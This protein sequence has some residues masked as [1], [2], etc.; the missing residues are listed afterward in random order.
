VLAEEM[1]APVG[2][3]ANITRLKKEL[4]DAVSQLVVAAQ[5]AGAI[6]TDIGPADVTMLFSGIAHAASLAGNVGTTL[7]ARYL[8]IMLDG[9]RPLEPTPLPGRP[10]RF[11]ELQRA[12]RRSC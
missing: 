1:S 12:K 7:R 5:E 6:R 3:P 8:T 2:L 4:Q 11:V 10:L 9:L